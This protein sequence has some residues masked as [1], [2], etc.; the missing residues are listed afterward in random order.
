MASNY[1]RRQ[2][3]NE[4]ET[5]E[6]KRNPTTPDP[7][8]NDNDLEFV[9][10]TQHDATR[11]FSTKWSFPP[12]KHT[13][14]GVLFRG[15]VT[16]STRHMW[17]PNTDAN[18]AKR[19]EEV[20]KYT[21]HYKKISSEACLIPCDPPAP[22]KNLRQAPAPIPTRGGRQVADP[23]ADTV[24][25]DLI[26]RPMEG[27]IDERL[28]NDHATNKEK[29]FKVSSFHQL[30]SRTKGKLAD[31]KYTC[32]LLCG[33]HEDSRFDSGRTRTAGACLCM[34]HLAAAAHGYLPSTQSEYIKTKCALLD[35]FRNELHSHTVLDDTILRRLQYIFDSA[36]WETHEKGINSNKY[37][38]VSVDMRPSRDNNGMPPHILSLCVNGL[39]ELL[40]DYKGQDKNKRYP[41]TISCYFPNEDKFG[42]FFLLAIRSEFKPGAYKRSLSN[43]GIEMAMPG[44]VDRNPDIGTKIKRNLLFQLGQD[45]TDK[46][47]NTPLADWYSHTYTTVKRNNFSLDYLVAL[48]VKKDKYV[49]LGCL[50]VM[51]HQVT[52][53]EEY[54][55]G[56][57]LPGTISF[58]IHVN[59]F[60]KFMSQARQLFGCS[61][62]GSGT[63]ASRQRASK[64]RTVI[65]HFDLWYVRNEFSGPARGPPIGPNDDPAGPLLAHSTAA[66]EPTVLRNARTK[67]PILLNGTHG[68]ACLYHYNDDSML[69]PFDVSVVKVTEEDS[70]LL[71][72]HW[73][74]QIK[75]LPIHP[76]HVPRP[77]P[78]ADE[79]QK[80]G[81]QIMMPYTKAVPGLLC[82]RNTVSLKSLFGE[83]TE[84]GL[85]LFDQRITEIAFAAIRAGMIHNNR[86]ADDPV[87]GDYNKT[88]VYRALQGAFHCGR[89]YTT[90][91]HT[92]LSR[93]QLLDL[94][95]AGGHAVSCL[96]PVGPTSTVV[97]FFSNLKDTQGWLTYVAPNTM[98][99][100]PATLMH[101]LGRITHLSGN[102]HLLVTLVF[103][104]ANDAT[105]DPAAFQLD[106]HHVDASLQALGEP[107]NK[108]ELLGFCSVQSHLLKA[109]TPPPPEDETE[110]P[111]K[112]KT[113]DL[114]FLQSAESKLHMDEFCI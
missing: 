96:I 11:T 8:L 30:T 74:D 26:Q 99:V 15:V 1:I 48:I 59:T 53:Y 50:P 114:G 108:E 47:V 22:D 14:R 39:R 2:D 106:Y 31:T 24:F 113:D 69:H 109:A 70:K 6:D 56:D 94:A 72:G 90:L 38:L 75:Y 105:L 27:Y 28:Y 17:E 36:F 77:T 85:D 67:S 87:I 55:R 10:V 68:T 91:P 42:T 46:L 103:T 16:N 40:G 52:L 65:A 4:Y 104:K 3:S 82:C 63:E 21:A 18:K 112:Q 79:R 13:V 97:R 35:E 51:P 64:M 81:S 20:E 43:K 92:V 89:K 32:F 76:D 88:I 29:R 57:V 100:F 9:N 23:E 7:C 54:V 34:S 12:K 102:P 33:D 98:L 71:W 111:A 37:N 78:A 95:A 83:E 62:S 58:P 73:Q 45:N 41:K 5:D 60:L 84:D 44:R 93:R 80:F 110:Q 19:G 49:V 61:D 86:D 101:E 25:Y 107:P 66:G